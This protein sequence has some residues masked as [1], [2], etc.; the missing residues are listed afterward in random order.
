MYLFEPS[1]GTYCKGFGGSAAPVMVFDGV[2][3]SSVSCRDK[4]RND[5]AQSDIRETSCG[6]KKNLFIF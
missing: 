3:F 6:P 2:F 4:K 1:S 5:R